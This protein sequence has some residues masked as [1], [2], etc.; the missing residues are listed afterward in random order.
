[1]IE[2]VKT[3]SALDG[4]ESLRVQSIISWN[5]SKLSTSKVYYR[6]GFNQDNENWPFE[7]PLDPTYTRRHL[8]VITDFSPGEVYQFQ[9][10][11][12][13]SNGQKIRSNTYTILTPRQRESVFQV[14]L[15]N[16]EQTFGWMGAF[17]NK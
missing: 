2:Q 7:T 12:E 1:M 16:I 17:N 8:V 13:D 6:K 15:K 11:S 4:A 9:V 5:T 10:E 3:S 14:I